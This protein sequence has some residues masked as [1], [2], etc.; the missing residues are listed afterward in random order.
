VLAFCGGGDGL[1]FDDEEDDEL[2]LLDDLLESEDDLLLLES[3]D[4]LLLLDSEEDE[5]ELE[6]EDN[7][8][9]LESEDGELEL[10][11]ELELD[12]EAALISNLGFTLSFLLGGSLE[13][14]EE[15]KLLDEDED[16]DDDDDD[17][18]DEDEDE[19]LSASRF[20]FFPSLLFLVSCTSCKLACDSG[21]LS[22][23]RPDSDSK[24]LAVFPKP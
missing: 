18:D 13:E 1:L 4:D 20:L 17:E 21:S 7:L 10:E 16:D 11:L 8:L 6:S 15:D 2:P 3:E 9:L 22:L 19:E 12:D 14:L 24:A 23:S 5:L